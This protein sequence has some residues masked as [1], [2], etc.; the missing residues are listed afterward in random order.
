MALRAVELGQD[1][2]PRQIRPDPAHS[3]ASGNSD[4]SADATGTAS[5][6][7]VNDGDG[8]EVFRGAVATSSAEFLINSVSIT[9]GGNVALTANVTW[10]AP[11]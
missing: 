9:S 11:S 7:R 5:Y 2:A 10:T 6:A 1:A 8:T 3:A 4:P